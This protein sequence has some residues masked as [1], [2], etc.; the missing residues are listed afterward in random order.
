MPRPSI[1]YLNARHGLSRGT[2]PADRLRNA[3]DDRAAFARLEHHEA[4][5]LQAEHLI[6]DFAAWSRNLAP[7]G[8]AAEEW[9]F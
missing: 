9:E 4:I 2:I 7:L 5:M 3:T 6:A 8:V 1:D